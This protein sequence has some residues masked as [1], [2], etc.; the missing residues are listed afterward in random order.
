MFIDECDSAAGIKTSRGVGVRALWEVL[1]GKRDGY[2]GVGPAPEVE[3]R[4]K[5]CMHGF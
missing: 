4:P 3:T 2:S 1:R 5:G